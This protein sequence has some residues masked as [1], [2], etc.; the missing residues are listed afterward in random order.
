MNAVAENNHTQA[1]LNRM[2]AK[3][4]KAVLNILDKWGCSPEQSM[5]I[6]RLPKATFYKYRSKPESIRL[7]R[8][9]LSR[10]SYLLNMHQSLRIVFENRDNVYG[11]MSKKNHNPFFN[12][13][14][15]LDVISSGEFAD[16]YET[17]KR[18][19]TLRGGLW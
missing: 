6:L 8:D 2:G 5:S 14:A 11:F 18:V 17:Y 7:D 1:D 9:Q 19:D 15:P 3:G 4:L 13:R 12:G 10:L 16:L